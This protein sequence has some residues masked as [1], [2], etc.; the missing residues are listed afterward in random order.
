MRLHPK[1]RLLSLLTN[2]RLGRKSQTVYLSEKALDYKTVGIT[3]TMSII[4]NTRP[5]SSWYCHE[6]VLVVLC[7]SGIITILILAILRKTSMFNQMP[8]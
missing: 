7:K 1:G 8:K 5:L 2:T 3:N 6:M 4:G